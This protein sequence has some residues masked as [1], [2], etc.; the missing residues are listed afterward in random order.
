MGR[1][2]GFLHDGSRQGH[3][4]TATHT[5]DVDHPIERELRELKV[6]AGHHQRT[7]TPSARISAR[8]GRATPPRRITKK[9]M[10]QV[11]SMF[12]A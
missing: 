9:I 7:E 1:W 8:P 2:R 10:V 11:P 5:P 6:Q 12:E 3:G 4:D